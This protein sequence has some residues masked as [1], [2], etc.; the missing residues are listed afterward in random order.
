ML[1]ALV[2]DFPE[3]PMVKNIDDSYLLGRNLL[4]A[5]VFSDEP[6]RAVYLP[7][8]TDWMYLHTGRWHRGGQCVRV[9]APIDV[10]PIFYRGGTATPRITPGQCV[11]QTPPQELTWEVCPFEG[12]AGYTYRAEHDPVRLDFALDDSGEAR[13]TVTGH[14]PYGLCL[15]IHAPNMQKLLINGLPA[16][17][18]W[19][20][21]T[22][23]YRKGASKEC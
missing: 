2:L 3:D 4:V 14:E 15:R 13:V 9:K 17:F 1:R 16:L 21:D 20:G 6:E 18:A 5:P 10:M 22:A 19:E 7:A 8:G 12:R 23:V 11:S